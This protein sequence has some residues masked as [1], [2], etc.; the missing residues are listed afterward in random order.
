MFKIVHA[1]LADDLDA[2]GTVN[3][4]YPAGYSK[5]YFQNGYAHKIRA[6]NASLKAPQDFTITLDTTYFTITLGASQTTIP[7]G[8]ALIIE[9]DRGSDY[10]TDRPDTLRSIVK[11]GRAVIGELVFVDLGS[12]KT[13]DANGYVESQNLTA[14]G[15]FSVNTTAAAAIAAA[16]LKGKPDVPRNVVASWTGTAVLTVTGKDVD[17]NVMKESSGSGTSFTGK[18]AFAEVTDV[19]VSANVTALTVG[20][21][22]VLG[23]PM[24][25]PDKGMVVRELKAGTTALAALTENSTSIGGTNDGNL[26][27]LVDPSGDAG[28]SLI[29]GVRECAAAINKL[30][31]FTG[32][33]VA[34]DDGLQS[35]TSGDVRGTY[36]PPVACDGATSFGLWIASLDPT[37]KGVDQYDG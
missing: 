26:P 24:Y 3:V 37:R 36:T 32:T 22:D 27:S 6:G 9:L 4:N 23:L 5:G 30:I 33:I 20:T 2:S 15:V 13:A 14:A 1:T 35:A 16:A 12:P 28:A 19:S 10:D 17:G 34:A 31:A 25:V 29:A 18:K 8:T 7:E 21:G 11:D